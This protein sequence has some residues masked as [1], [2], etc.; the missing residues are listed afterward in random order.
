M[1]AYHACISCMHIMHAYHAC[2]TCM[3]P[4]KRN[5]FFFDSMGA[6]SGALLRGR[7]PL[8]AQRCPQFVK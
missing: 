4:N 8:T 3:H 7:V 2:M 5:V 1:H 6:V